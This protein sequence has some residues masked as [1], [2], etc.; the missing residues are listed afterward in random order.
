ATAS[1]AD[2]SAPAASGWPRAAAPPSSDP[3]AAPE[4]SHRA[5]RWRGS[6]CPSARTTPSGTTRRD[7]CASG[8]RA[9]P[10][11]RGTCSSRPIS[12]TPAYG[13]SPRTA[14]RE[15]GASARIIAREFAP[16]ARSS[17]DLTMR[18]A[19]VILLL[20]TA[21]H[22]DTAPHKEGQYGGVTPG[23]IQPRDTA[24]KP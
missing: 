12:A 3:R 2:C 13:R 7:R 6:R 19:L 9:D 8:G 5:S 11:A 22:A 15:P 1:P 23:E 17:Y 14:R 10:R 4:T 21:A 18:G 16:G 24:G 20:A